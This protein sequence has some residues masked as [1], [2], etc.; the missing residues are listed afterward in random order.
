MGPR[1]D[2]RGYGLDR[3][4]TA[5]ARIEASMGPRSDNRGY[6]DRGGAPCQAIES[7]KW[8]H[9]PRTGVMSESVS[10]LRREV[11]GLQWVHGPITVVMGHGRKSVQG[12]LRLQW[13]HGPITVVML[14]KAGEKLTPY[15]RFNGSTVR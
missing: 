12:H 5:A 3:R 14:R 9:G 1:S 6:A 4:R 2:N 7:L 15:Q 13:V 8:V 10:Q 11:W